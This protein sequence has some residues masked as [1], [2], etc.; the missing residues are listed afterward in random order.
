MDER[1]IAESLVKANGQREV[2]FSKYLN[3]TDKMIT[4]GIKVSQLAF[5]SNR[6]QAVRGGS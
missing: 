4:A 1:Q 2:D 5:Q 3:V 6:A